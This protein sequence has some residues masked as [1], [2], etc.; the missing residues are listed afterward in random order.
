MAGEAELP[1]W[2]TLGGGAAGIIIATILARLGWSSKTQ[3]DV[4]EQGGLIGALVD[5]GSVR[6]LT[7]A[8]QSHT[9][10][11]KSG[12]EHVEALGTEVRNLGD[13]VRRL[14]NKVERP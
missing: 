5:S 13:E 10:V 11:T 4:P 12:F 3:S 7:L 8:I 14:G 2:L 1:Q 6:E 9:E